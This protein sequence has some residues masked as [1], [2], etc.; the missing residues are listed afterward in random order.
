MSASIIVGGWDPYEGGQVYCIPL[1][2]VLVRQPFAIGGKR[3]V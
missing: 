1:G 3:L 2:G